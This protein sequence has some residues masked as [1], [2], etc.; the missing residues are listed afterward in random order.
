MA[1]MKAIVLFRPRATS[2]AFKK[3]SDGKAEWIR[4]GVRNNHLFWLTDPDK[5]NDT[6]DNYNSIQHMIRTSDI[7]SILVIKDGKKT[8]ISYD[9]FIENYADIANASKDD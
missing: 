7:E 2:A 3:A 1:M 4:A 5:P 6:Q 9:A 8:A